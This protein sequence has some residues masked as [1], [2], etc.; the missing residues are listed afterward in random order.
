MPRRF[1]SEALR[2]IALLA[3]L[4]LIYNSLNLS[5]GRWILHPDD[6]NVYV[7]SNVLLHTGRLWY[8]SEYNIEFETGAF[9]PGLDDYVM[10]PASEARIRAPYSPGVFVLVCVGHIFGYKGPFVVVSLVGI[11]GLFFLYLAM[12]KLYGSEVAFLAVFLM[13]FSSAYIYWNN[14]LFSNVPALSFAV[15]GLYFTLSA[16]KEP[17]KLNNYLLAAAFFVFSVWIRYEFVILALLCMLPVIWNMKKLRLRNA[18]YAFILLMALTGVVLA[19]NYLTTGGFFG[20]PQKAG[21]TATEY[22]VKYPARF[23]GVEVLSNNWEMYVFGVAPL[24]TVLG[25]AGLFYTLL[26]ERNV[27]AVSLMFLGLM[28]FYYYGNNSK[29]WGYGKGWMAAS[30]TRYFL[31]LFMVLSCFAAVFVAGFPRKRGW[32]EST[33]SLILFMVLAVHAATSLSL[34]GSAEFGLSYTEEYMRGRRAVEEFAAYLPENA[35]V[36]DLTDAWYEKMIVSRTV[37]LPSRVVKGGSGEMKVAEILGALL[38]SGVEVYVFHNPERSVLSPQKLAD[39]NA[40]FSFQPVSHGIVIAKGGRSP[41]IYRLT[42]RDRAEA[43]GV[44]RREPEAGAGV[45]ACVRGPVSGA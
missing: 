7:F 40:D 10:V 43:T 16:V 18:L 9:V 14:M 21:A 42:W 8:Q 24:L 34:L 45:D 32:K 31:P 22:A 20:I 17:E 5:H 26:H 36:V 39:L 2:I 29:F 6:K 11:I 44:E 28:V 30:Y 4:F 12:R 23:K 25:C 13:G 37:F 38:D 41:E 1:D 33:C 27:Y 3:V 35:V 15:G 19:L